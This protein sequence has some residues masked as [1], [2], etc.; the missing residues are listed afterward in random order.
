MFSNN[1]QPTI[2]NNLKNSKKDRFEISEQQLE[3]IKEITKIYKD[4][5]CI[6]IHKL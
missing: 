3:K 6:E 5:K 1:V 2:E 4:S